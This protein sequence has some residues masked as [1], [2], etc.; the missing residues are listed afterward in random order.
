MNLLIQFS[1]GMVEC[2]NIG[3]M[4]LEVMQYWEMAKAIV[5]IKLNYMI[6]F[7]NPLFHRSTIPLFHD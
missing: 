3:K 6:S 2:W 5:T 1:I 7:E 4:G